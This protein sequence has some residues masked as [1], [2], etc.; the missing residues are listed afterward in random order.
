MSKRNKM[1]KDEQLKS[2]VNR[3]LISVVI[4][5]L[6]VFL[7]DRVVSEIATGTIPIATRTSTTATFESSPVIF[8]VYAGIFVL[9]SFGF[10]FAGIWGVVKSLK[11]IVRSDRS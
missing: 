3:L 8:S 9:G 5:V 10:T 6:G 11:D 1:S 4:T 2:P 7:S